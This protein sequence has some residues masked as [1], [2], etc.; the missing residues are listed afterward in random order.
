[1]LDVRYRAVAILL[2]AQN[3]I[4]LASN[5]CTAH[6]QQILWQ[7]LVLAKTDTS[8]LLRHRN[9]II[10]FVSSKLRSKLGFNFQ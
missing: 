7:M 10:I 6:D 1:M 2:V 8:A 5:E 9:A 3:F 4:P